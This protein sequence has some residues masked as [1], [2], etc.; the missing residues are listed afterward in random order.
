MVT[1]GNC[2]KID[3]VNI[4]YL[5]LPAF[6]LGGDTIICPGD[7]ILL[8]SANNAVSYLWS[9]GTT[10]QYNMVNESGIYWAEAYSAQCSYK[11]S[12]KIEY[13]HQP[14]L[15]VDTVLCSNT[16]FK[17]DLSFADPGGTYLWNTGATTSF[18]NVYEPGVYSVILT[19]NETCQMF[20]TIVVNPLDD[21]PPLFIPNSFTPNGDGLNELFNPVGNNDNIIEFYFAVYNR[22]GE[23]IFETRD[24]NKGWDG[25]MNNQNVQIGV[26]VYKI[27]YSSYCSPDKTINKFGHIVL[28][29]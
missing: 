5:P 9:N 12:I 1:A 14:Y 2:V 17:L 7:S 16:L 28:L 6:S 11:D 23:L 25:T 21:D 10:N 15:G 27:D 18:L 3:S 19:Y 22:W 13:Y 8:S 24:R 26:Y 4:T 29:R 20:D